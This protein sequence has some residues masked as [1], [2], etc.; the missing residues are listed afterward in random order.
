[1][2]EDKDKFVIHE[3]IMNFINNFIEEE[4]LWKSI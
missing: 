4:G 3:E 2:C 1:M